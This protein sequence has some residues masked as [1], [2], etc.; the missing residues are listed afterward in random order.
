MSKAALRWIRALR[1]SASGRAGAPPRSNSDT[2]RRISLIPD[3]AVVWPD[4]T[5]DEPRFADEERPT[6]LRRGLF[7]TSAPAPERRTSDR[8][9]YLTELEFGEDAQFFTGLSL[10]VSDGGLFVA[11]YQ[12]IPLGTRLVLCFELPNGASVEA[13]GEVRWVRREGD[14]GGRPGVGIAFTELPADARDHIAALCR[15]RPP[16]YLDL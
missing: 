1:D 8:A 14:D 9:P 11:T 7:P 5:G 3:S 13:R 10:D 12:P 16:L 2:F 15:E 4:S 6:R